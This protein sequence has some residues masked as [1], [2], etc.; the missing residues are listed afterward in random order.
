MSFEQGFR[1]EVIIRAP[2]EVVW[3]ALTNPEEIARW[4]GWDY[5]GLPDEITM[6][7]VDGVTQEPPTRLLLGWEQTIELVADGP[8]V[9]I[10]RIVKPGPLATASWDDLYDEMVRG[11]HGFLL[12]LRHYLERHDGESRH[13]L[14]LDG[15]AS[16]KAVLAALDADIPG[17]TWVNS[18]YQRVTA[19]DGF[20]GGL[21]AVLSAEPLVSDLPCKVQVTITTHGL[22][23]GQFAALREQVASRWRALAPDGTVTP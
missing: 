21:V 13:T 6:I 19:V 14:W 9:T 10:V 16:P 4:F 8:D 20:G 7:F 22:D 11:W 2:R 18:R 12:Q 17:E 3:R 23:D 5:E 15:T 1:V